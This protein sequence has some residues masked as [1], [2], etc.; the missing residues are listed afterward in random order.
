MLGA[1]RMRCVSLQEEADEIS[2]VF[3]KMRTIPTD[4]DLLD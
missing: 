3:R 2:G 1:A 4:G